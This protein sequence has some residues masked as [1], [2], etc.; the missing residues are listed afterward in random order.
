MIAALL[1][2]DPWSQFLGCVF[3]ASV[4]LALI[5]RGRGGAT[6]G[7]LFTGVVGLALAVIGRH[8]A[9]SDAP[10]PGGMFPGTLGWVALAL[11]V[12]GGLGAFRE[13]RFGLLVGWLA[14][15]QAGVIILPLAVTGEDGRTAALVGFAVAVPAVHGALLARGRRNFASVILLLALVGL[16]P[17]G[18]FVVRFL[19][20]GAVVGAGFP[21]LMLA[22]LVA[23]IL[24]VAAV[25][26]VLRASGAGSGGRLTTVL[27]AFCAVLVLA[28]GILWSPL[29]RLAAA[30]ADLS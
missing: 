25:L 28:M 15:A 21:V 30:A 6:T 16:P 19:A 12:V 1:T 10:V 20:F 17:T 26:R 27:A 11:I 23:G 18:G 24:P 5:S 4:V 7:V 29:A 8:L 2:W 22:G 9:T 3:L 13:T 14:V